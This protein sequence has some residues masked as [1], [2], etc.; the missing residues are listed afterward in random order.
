MEVKAMAVG[1]V[2]VAPRSPVLSLFSWISCSSFRLFVAGVVIVVV[3]CCV[4]K[5][6]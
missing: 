1:I 4:K 6:Q 3:L 5:K 2:V